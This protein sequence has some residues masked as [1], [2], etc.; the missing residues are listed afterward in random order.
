MAALIGVLNGTLSASLG[1]HPLIVTLGVG[2]FVSGAVL[3]WTKGFTGGR[4]PS[5]INQFVS[6]GATLG[7]YAM[8]GVKVGPF[9]FPAVVP[10]VL[11]GG[12]VIGLVLEWTVY[13]R[14]LYDALGSNPN[15]A[16]LAL[17]CPV[18]IWGMTYALSA[19]F[20]AI[21]GVLLLGSQEA[22]L[23]VWARLICS[24]RSRPSKLVVLYCSADVE[25]TT[26]IGAFVLIELNTVLIGLGL[27]QSLV[28]AALGVVIVIL[29][30]VYGR[31][32]AVRTRI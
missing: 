16:R 14:Q 31:E 24:K 11:I 22:P 7:P 1:I 12:L 9:P 2:I 18:F 17:V 30:A 29:V 5:F 15:A 28:Q 26:L 21:A 10:V 3:E 27:S 13:G 6:I 4:L 32:V 19:I 25:V 8:F 20:A 23:L